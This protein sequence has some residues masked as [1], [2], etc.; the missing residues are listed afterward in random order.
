MKRLRKI[1]TI[2]T[3]AFLISSPST[4]CGSTYVHKVPP[5]PI[6]QV[7]PVRPY[8]GAVWIGGHWNWNA[9]TDSYVW[10]SGYWTRSKPGRTWVS[11]HWVK[12][13]RG[14]VWVS[15]HWR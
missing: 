2:L 6:H 5:A 4:G 15:G 13:P 1:V 3:F 14:W 12:R 11:G 8:A 9:R 10:L 7:R